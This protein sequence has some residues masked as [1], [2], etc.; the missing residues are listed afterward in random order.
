MGQF[1]SP[2]TA[3]IQHQKWEVCVRNARA[4][5]KLEELRPQDIVAVGAVDLSQKVDFTTFSVV[6]YHIPSGMFYMKHFF[7]VPEEQVQDKC[8][9]DSPMVFKWIEQKHINGTPGPTVNYE[10]MFRDM[11]DA[12]DKYKIDEVLYD[13]W[14]AG[15]LMDRIG[16][17]CTLVEV[18]QN[19]QSI[20]PMA[21]DYEA[22]VLEGKIVDD[23][24]VMSWMISNCDIYRD[25]NGNIKPVK[26]GGK[27]SP[28]HIDG[29]ITSLMG[30]GRLKSLID[31]GY[32]DNR[33]P[34]EI[35]KDME[36]RLALIE[37]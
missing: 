16:P 31:G 23:N 1:L 27:D 15:Q 9:T 26:H 8:K 29:V 36:A 22:C 21:K 20:S 34:E 4:L 14:N 24:P 5:P 2:V 19:Y 18:K 10:V 30:V 11:E 6:I 37:Y 28:L 13:P 33:S 7:Y 17:L 32:I 35:Q 3:W 12:I 25:Q